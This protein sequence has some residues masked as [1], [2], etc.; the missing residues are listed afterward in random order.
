MQFQIKKASEENVPQ[1]IEL[2]REFAEYENLLDAF[3]VTEEKLRD[4][5]FGENKIADALIAFDSENPIAY[6]IFYPCFA[7]FRGQR[8][9]YLEDIYIKK[10]F[11]AHKL[12]EALLKQIA[13]IAKER[14]C[15]RIDFQVLNWNTP[16]IE[17]YKKHGAE[18]DE[19][20]RHFKFAGD[21]FEKLAL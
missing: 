11:R 14:G 8:G 16:A 18:I 6:A 3:E 20:E 17:F 10:E 7:T 9:M 19:S 21:A 12:G 13:Q 4:A 5:L 1:I 15:A 2:L